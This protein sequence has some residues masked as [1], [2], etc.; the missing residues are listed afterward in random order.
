MTDTINSTVTDGVVVL[1]E[2][3][4]VLEDNTTTL[5]ETT[6]WIP[7]PIKMT[8]MSLIIETLP[9][10]PSKRIVLQNILVE[11]TVKGVAV[12]LNTDT[13]NWMV[14]KML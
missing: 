12:V 5:L 1:P 2:K 4:L 6:G 14:V 9:V 11:R 3:I 8:V 10:M 7:T 13:L